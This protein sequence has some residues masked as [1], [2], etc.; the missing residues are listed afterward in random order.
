MTW[1]KEGAARGRAVL[2]ARAEQMYQAYAS[3]R[4]RYTAAQAA[5]QRRISAPTARKYERR[6]QAENAS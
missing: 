2:S 5:Q 1:T 6:Y 3:L 4:S